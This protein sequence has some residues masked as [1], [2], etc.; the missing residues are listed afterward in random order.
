MKMTLRKRCLAL[1]AGGLM[2]VSA[3]PVLAVEQA[4]SVD[5]LLKLISS[6]RI[7]ESQE[8]KQRE[9]EFQRNRQ[10]QQRLLDQSKGVVATEEARSAEL[11]QTF[12]DND[13]KIEALRGQLNERL[14]SLRE[15]F[16]HLTSS[17]G[18]VR[19]TIN[20]SIITAQYPD[21]GVFIDELIAKMSS[22][23]RLPS[24]AEIERLWAE[25]SRE[26]VESGKVVKFPATVVTAQGDQEQREV[27]RIGSFNLVS[28]GKYLD[29]N[30]RS[31]IIS[32]LPRQPAAAGGA[33][34][35]QDATSGFTSVAIDP[36]G[37]SGGNLLKALVDSPS[38]AEKFHQGGLVGY[39]ITG[40]GVF[41]VLLAIWRFGVLSSM[42]AKVS[43]QLK[44]PKQAQE[45]NPLGRVLKVAE[46]NP[47]LDPNSLELKL[48]EVVLK[49]RPSIEMGLNLLKVIAAV[50]PLL[51]LLG[52]VTGMIVTFQQITI[53]GAGDPKAMA[54]GISMAL[55]TTV[56]GLCVAI[57]MVLLHTL[58]NGRAQRVLHVLEEQSA[59]IIA[60]NAE[61]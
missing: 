17:A 50:A 7:G 29:Y 35:L 12:A 22:D 54:G 5:E 28:D 48:N 59:G 16:G 47:G 36:T 2:A 20:E 49:E 39:I 61:G 60:E 41:G 30:A 52:T 11:E 38:L 44:N 58:L 23:T 4:A 56:Q 10:D 43:R 57:P 55:V 51:G 15:L 1:V 26:M 42:S 14:G 31:S 13:L 53:F 19:A 46:N 21:R 40:I 33:A 25:M 6:A 9:A 27:V 3:A 37:P 32:E 45:N 34:K 18:D 24:L 8:H